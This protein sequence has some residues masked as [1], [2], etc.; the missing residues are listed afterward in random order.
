M[1]NSEQIRAGRAIVDGVVSLFRPPFVTLLAITILVPLAADSLASVDRRFDGGDLVIALL[2]AAVSL[3]VQIAATLAAGRAVPERSGDMWLRAAWRRRC[4][5][6]VVWATL[7]STAA[8]VGGVALAGIGIFF[9]GAVL[10]FTQVAVVLERRG[11][12]DAVARSV[13]L[14]RGHRF[15]VGIAFAVLFILPNVGV[16]AASLTG[17]PERLGVVWAALSV[18]VEVLALAGT[19][20][21]TR[22][23]VAAGG[24]ATPA[25]LKPA[26][27]TAGVG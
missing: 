12:L 21:L 5:W 18:L 4:F 3:Y 14:T 6:K 8:L 15:P 19:I 25:E 22:M 26:R 11:P 23:F 27:V 2:L 9:V 24:D 16:W 17:I 10:A 1:S 20:A 13:A 7:I